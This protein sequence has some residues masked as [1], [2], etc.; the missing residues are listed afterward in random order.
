[1]SLHGVVSLDGSEAYRELRALNKALVQFS[2]DTASALNLTATVNLD[3]RSLK[4]A[5]DAMSGLS[6]Q[7]LKELREVE[8]LRESTSK[9]NAQDV[10]RAVAEDQRASQQRQ[11]HQRELLAALKVEA[12]QHRANVA[13]IR[14]ETAEIAKSG[15]T[16]RTVYQQE[17][18]DIRQLREAQRQ[19]DRERREADRIARDA[20][21]HTR[22]RNTAH[23]DLL[24]RASFG[25]TVAGGSLLA[26]IGVS[27]K[28]FIDFDRQLRNINTVAQL[29]ESELQ[30][31]GDSIIRLSKDPN[32]RKG[33][34]DLAAALYDIYS[35]GQEGAQ[36]LDTLKASAIGA[37]AGLTE[38]SNA[39]GVTLSVLQSGIPGVSNSKESL[40]VLFKT[41]DRGRLTFEELSSTLGTVLPTA[42][43]AGIPLQELGAYLAVATKQGQSASEATNDLSNLIQKLANP[44]KEARGAFE[45]LGIQYGFSALQAKGLTGVLDQIQAKTHGNADAIKVLLPDMQAQRAAL[46]GLTDSGRALHLELGEQAKAFDGAGAAARAM[47]KQNQG[48]A[49]EADLLAKE[50]KILAIETGKAAAPA[51]HA[52]VSEA[53]DAVKWFNSLDDATQQS[54]V[55]WGLYGGAALLVVGKIT[56]IAEVINL[57]KIAHNTAAIA[58][59]THATAEEIAAGR[60]VRAWTL[61]LGKLRTLFAS[62]LVLRIAQVGGPGAIGALLGGAGYAGLQSG[63]ALGKEHPGLLEAANNAQ[64][65]FRSALTPKW[66]WSDDYINMWEGSTGYDDW[67]KGNQAESQA[68]DI[69]KQMRDRRTAGQRKGD[70]LYQNHGRPLNTDSNAPKSVG[71]G[72]NPF[73]GLETDEQRKAREKREREELQAQ[74]RLLESYADT[75]GHKA[76][77]AQRWA[78]GE[79]NAI[80]S[81]QDALKSLNSEA[82]NGLREAGVL[83][84]PLGGHIRALQEF[85]GLDKQAHGAVAHARDVIKDA[86]KTEQE[87]RDAKEGKP[88]APATGGKGTT[89]PADAKQFTL[90]GKKVSAAT[91]PKE[92]DSFEDLL[93]DLTFSQM[94]DLPRGW[95]KELASNDFNSERVRWQRGLQSD[96]A[97]EILEK[98]GQA[99]ARPG[100]LDKLE[101]AL[102]IKFNLQGDGSG[103]ATREDMA[104]NLLRQYAN[105]LD[106]ISNPLKQYVGIQEKLKDLL[107]DVARETKAVLQAERDRAA[108]L[109]IAN[110]DIAKT[111]ISSFGLNTPEMR[112]EFDKL[113]RDLHNDDRLKG[114][115]EE[116]KKLRALGKSTEADEL[117]EQ[118]DDE[119]RKRFIAKRNTAYLEAADAYT[120]WAKGA[121]K[122]LTEGLDKTMASLVPTIDPGAI[123]N[124]AQGVDPLQRTEAGQVDEYNALA[125]IGKIPSLVSNALADLSGLLPSGKRDTTEYDQALLFL[126]EQRDLLK[127]RPGLEREVE[128]K[129]LELSKGSFNQSEAGNLLGEYRELLRDQ[130]KDS[131]SQDFERRSATLGIY[132]EK[133]LYFAEL[134]EAWKHDGLT[135]EE[136]A[137][138][139][140]VEAWTLQQ[141][142]LRNEVLTLLDGLEGDFKSGFRTM[143]D[144]GPK[145]F[146][147]S[148]VNGFRDTLADMASDFLAS[149]VRDL[150]ASL[151]QGA[152]GKGG[153]G[154]GLPGGEPDLLG[155]GYDPGSQFGGARAKGGPVGA[156][157]T[158][159]VGEK[160]PELFR[161]PQAGH[162]VP[163]HELRALRELHRSLNPSISMER[164]RPLAQQSSSGPGGGTVNHFNLSGITVNANNPQ[165]FIE[166]LQRETGRRK[167]ISGNRMSTGEQESRLLERLKRREQGY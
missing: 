116:A 35:S 119:F 95:G 23:D 73:E 86:R 156:G 139:L 1:M 160:G 13:A 83:G 70:L 96:K 143:F 22:K 161:A 24:D 38:T 93:K 135:D 92:A 4:A 57:V 20:A 102:G 28:E 150:F 142:K 120:D 109:Q 39:A 40:D 133:D 66:L 80:R 100:A 54:I 84:N 45:Q 107:P 122:G 8:R 146:F 58:A 162:I 41:V 163:N 3:A 111:G 64:W 59:G 11:N 55:K 114:M 121:R 69:L 72:T 115:Y 155:M 18:R 61:G 67:L 134:K 103:N 47:T 56:K 51:M 17:L 132:R 71:T 129:R 25:A 145:G 43:K 82:Q 33:P 48:A 10:R 124:A 110:P 90:K 42:A 6:T 77:A 158:Y 65:R 27:S 94:R 165:E 153:G 34:D 60:S 74:R 37:S 76:D 117:E 9:A 31:L 88:L 85:L 36:A 101:K 75:Y 112:A 15:A 89:A 2:K 81:V 98:V 125:Q 137:G 5:Q 16:A 127:A 131:L 46:T 148:L 118:A 78:T 68:V 147:D 106:A 152:L 52:L 49:Y 123:F 44:S 32:I 166:A 21:A 154:G 26:G 128:A 157:M 97:P 144:E 63:G 53:R 91:V 29:S 30:K 126:Q 19:S 14:L 136:V 12:G 62:P 151:A 79:V 138:M 50:M 159:L 108:N 113:W 141:E 130:A 104:A 164:L 7:Q 149:Q 105:Q 167:R 99:I 140:N 87:L